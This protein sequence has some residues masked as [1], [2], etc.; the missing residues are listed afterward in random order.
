[1]TSKEI[2]EKFHKEHDEF[3][4][5]H[6]AAY[7]AADDRERSKLVAAQIARHN[8]WVARLREALTDASD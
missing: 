3:T 8:D 6:D 5:V 4:R 1:M 2:Q 7:E